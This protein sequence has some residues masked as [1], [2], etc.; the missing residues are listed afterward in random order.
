VPVKQERTHLS[1]LGHLADDV[2]PSFTYF[3]DASAHNLYSFLSTIAK[4]LDA[5]SSIPSGRVPLD[6][7]GISCPYTLLH[8]EPF[9]STKFS[10][11]NTRA[12]PE[13]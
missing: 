5:R 6:I 8:E 12:P 10:H 3:I 4:A 1:L 2:D 9:V 7:L 11:L 13:R